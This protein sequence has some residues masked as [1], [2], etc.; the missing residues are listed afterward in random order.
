MANRLWFLRGEKV[1]VLNVRGEKAGTGF[2]KSYDIKKNS[3]QVWFLYEASEERELI[4][5]P[6][7]LVAAYSGQVNKKREG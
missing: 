3:Y 5:I 4:E 7:L 2:V 6:A 1:T